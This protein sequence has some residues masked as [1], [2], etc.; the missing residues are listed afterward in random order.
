MALCV[1][2]VYL[3][4]G[5]GPG[6]LAVCAVASL[7]TILVLAREHEDKTFLLR[8]F[9]LAVMARIIIA[10]VIHTAGLEEF[11]GGDATTSFLICGRRSRI[12]SSRTAVPRSLARTYRC[13][14]YIDWPTPTSAAS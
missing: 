14:S 10:T 3:K 12:A 9:V 2:V 1:S 13:I 8:V 7:P 11:F 4:P 6:A 5:V